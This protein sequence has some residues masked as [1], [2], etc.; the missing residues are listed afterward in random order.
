MSCTEVQTVE[1]LKR[2]QYIFLTINK[3]N[4]PH[5]APTLLRNTVRHKHSLEEDIITL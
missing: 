2:W 1:S 5:M 3:E 4:K